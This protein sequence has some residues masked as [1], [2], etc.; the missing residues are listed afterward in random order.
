MR[1]RPGLLG[2][3]WLPARTCRRLR[4]QMSWIRRSFPAFYVASQG[5]CL[6]GWL[7]HWKDRRAGRWPRL[8]YE[9]RGPT[10]VARCGG[11]KKELDHRRFRCWRRSCRR[12]LYPDRD[13]QD[14]RRRSPGLA[15][16]RA[17]PPF[18]ITPL[19]ETDDL[20]S[21]DMLVRGVA[22]P[23]LRLQTAAVGRLKS[24]GFRAQTRMH[25]A[26]GESPPGF[27]CQTHPLLDLG[28]Y[29]GRQSLKIRFERAP[30]FVPSIF[31]VNF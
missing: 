12:R 31:F 24:N 18:Q 26:P 28:R 2:T 4:G 14:E 8:S 19:R 16:R 13:L 10:S 25:S 6:G 3:R 29:I 20:S 22:V 5:D 9:Q 15:R 17:R 1:R 27:K 21:P 11:R 30:L 7:R 23:C